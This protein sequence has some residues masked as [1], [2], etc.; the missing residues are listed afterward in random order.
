[1][2]SGLAEQSPIYKHKVSDTLAAASGD[3]LKLAAIEAQGNFIRV[4]CLAF[5]RISENL[6][7]K[8]PGEG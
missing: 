2:P 7:L 4:I 1:M 8:I 5:R 6:A 3:S